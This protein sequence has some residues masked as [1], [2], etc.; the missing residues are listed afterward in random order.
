MSEPKFEKRNFPRER[1]SGARACEGGGGIA[2]EPPV[3]QEG[4]GDG[5]Q[6]IENLG[7]L[8][9]LENLGKSAT[10]IYP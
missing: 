10:D 1:A 6:S 2:G 7:R 3:G 9:M 4:G 8:G 5:A